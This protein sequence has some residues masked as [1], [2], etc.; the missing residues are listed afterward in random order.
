MNAKTIKNGVWRSDK[1][2]QI[3]KSVVTEIVE[4]KGSNELR[5][6]ITQLT[7]RTSYQ[8][9]KLVKEWCK[10]LPTFT[11][12]EHLWLPSRV[13]QI[14]FDAICELPNL[15]TLWI[16]WSGIKR[17][18]NIENLNKLEHLHIGSSSKIE[19]I[20]PLSSLKSLITLETEQLNKIS[21]FESIGNLT[22]LEGLGI[23]GSIWG[24]QKIESLDFIR[25]LTELKYFTMTN[26]RLVSKSFEP[27]LALDKLVRFNSSWNY[28]AKEFEKLKAHPSLKFGNVETSWKE[29]KAELDKKMK[30]KSWFKFK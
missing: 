20:E 17:I 19:S 14:I 28:P 23:D 13:N 26:S 4:Y 1:L 9:S 5:L 3:N 21:N 25:Q 24:T 18:N 2:N 7:D 10:V 8:Q 27:L 11:S 22:Q 15:K 12:I 30:R 16:K 6:Y 29:L